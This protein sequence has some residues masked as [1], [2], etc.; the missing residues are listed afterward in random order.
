MENRELLAG[1]PKTVLPIPHL[2][3][4]GCHHGSVYRLIAETIDELGIQDKAVGCVG[5]GCH[6]FGFMFLDIDLVG[7]LHGRAPAVAT[8][9][10]RSLYGKPIVF[11]V[12]GDGDLAAIG[13]GA[14]LNAAI[15][16]E[17]LTTIFCNNAGYGTTGGQLAP[18]TLLDQKTTTTPYGR[19]PDLE[20]YPVHMAELMATFRG[21][22][23]SAR[24][25]LTSRAN[26]NKA[27]K[28][29]KKAFQRQIEGIGYGFVE[30]LEACPSTLKLSPR[31]ALKWV[32]SHMME[33]YPLGE[34]KDV[35][36]IQ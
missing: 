14:I 8:G 31:E 25:S 26:Y 7:C 6:A 2:Y 34:F 9:I 24:C 18:T 10:K 16:G 13:M 36:S 28:A 15:R 22:A 32:E 4:P 20:G 17:K 21:V 33:E 12:Q 3:C 1:R 23:Y 19:S 35:D 29:M 5:V 27:A 30:I 11:T